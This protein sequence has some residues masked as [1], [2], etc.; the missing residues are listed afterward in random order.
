MTTQTTDRID[1]KCAVSGEGGGDWAPH[2]SRGNTVIC[3]CSGC[4]EVMI[5]DYGCTHTESI[6][7]A[8]ACLCIE[9][10]LFGLAEVR[11]MVLYGTGAERLTDSL[12]QLS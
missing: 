10:G 11:E 6:E 3:L 4:A 12:G 1:D 5:T 2:A 9:I 8:S 7:Q